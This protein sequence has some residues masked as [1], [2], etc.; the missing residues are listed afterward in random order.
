MDYGIAN[1]LEWAREST[2]CKF[3]QSA[4]KSR[5]INSAFSSSSLHHT[6]SIDYSSLTLSLSFL[7]ISLKLQIWSFNNITNM[8]KK[9]NKMRKIRSTM[10]SA[11]IIGGGRLPTLVSFILLLRLARSLLRFLSERV[12]FVVYLSVC[13]LFIFMFLILF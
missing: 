8:S 9:E 5:R 1:Y 12:W 10:S 11:L 4:V 13:Q 2:V 3:L 6:Q 7:Q